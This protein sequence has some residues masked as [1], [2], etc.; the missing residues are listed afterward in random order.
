MLG[1]VYLRTDEQRAFVL[2]D[3]SSNQLPHSY[4]VLPP[5]GLAFHFWQRDCCWSRELG[6]QVVDAA[7]GM[8]TVTQLQCLELKPKVPVHLSPCILH[9]QAFPQHGSVSLCLLALLFSRQSVFGST[10]ILLLYR[11]SGP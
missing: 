3:S 1:W 2:L 9:L 5:L 6:Q 4:T 7:V 8:L 10:S 11:N